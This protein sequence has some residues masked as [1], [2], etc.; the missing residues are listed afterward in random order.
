M[1][2]TFHHH[3]R[4]WLA[5]LAF[6]FIIIGG[7]LLWEGYKSLGTP[8]TERRPVRAL[9][10]FIAAGACMA[11]AANGIRERHRRQDSDPNNSR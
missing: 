5:R 6:S 2:R 7:V 4:R 9:T 3:L 8:T 11:L 10:C 1:N